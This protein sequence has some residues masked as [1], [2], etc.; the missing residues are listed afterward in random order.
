MEIEVKFYL[1]EFDALRNRLL[2]LNAC[3]GGKFFE[4]NIRFEDGGNSLEQKKSLLR[5]RRDRKNTLTFKSE[6]PDGEKQFKIHNEWE[7]EVSDFSTMK[8]IL[9]SVGFHQA[10]IYEKWRETF[11]L[12]D[13]VL[14][15]DTL[16]F[17]NFV[18]I[19]GNKKQI[20]ALA[21]ELGFKW[22][23]RILLNYLA[24]FDILKQKLNLS[25]HD[26]TFANFKDIRIDFGRYLHLFEGGDGMN[27]APPA[28]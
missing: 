21:A 12:Q 9:E 16:P 8:H 28:D 24:L 14:C 26:I 11:S 6:L 3:N 19:E 13:T 7:V 5:L 18:E 10:Q 20:K 1:P 4:S 22:P 25:F 17:G 2:G 23:T 27:T 15:L